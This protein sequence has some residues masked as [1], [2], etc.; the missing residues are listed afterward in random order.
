MEHPVV[1]TTLSIIADFFE[2]APIYF[3]CFDENLCF[4]A[5]NKETLKLLQFENK[6]DIIGKHITTISP[7]LKNSGRLEIYE[8]VIKTGIPHQLRSFRLDPVLGGKHTGAYAFKLNT[9]IALIGVDVTEWVEEETKIIKKLEQTNKE[10]EQFAYVASH[11][12]QEPLETVLSFTGVIKDKY[13]KKFDDNADTYFGFVVQAAKRMQCLVRDILEYGRV[14]KHGDAEML[15][16]NNLLKDVLDT[17]AASIEKNKAEITVEELPVI[18]ANSSDMIQ[19]F[20]NLL[21]NAIKFRQKDINPVISVSAIKNESNEW[22]FSIKDNGIGIDEKFKDRIFIIFQRL[23]NR[24]QYEGTGIGL[25]LCKKIVEVN[26]GKI[27]LESKPGSG[28]T[29]YFTL[30]ET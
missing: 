12:L 13:G 25:A 17:L 10:L 5:L 23:H 2:E 14:G 19:L 28:S 3:S 7:S 22:L 8:S 16:M 11:D 21:S 9:G 29:F 6:E 20:Q 27:W 26:G 4:T 15:N 18:K 1:S 30:S 24:T